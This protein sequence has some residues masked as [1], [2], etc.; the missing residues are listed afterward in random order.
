MMRCGRENMCGPCWD[1]TPDE[2]WAICEAT[3]DLLGEISGHTAQRDRIRAVVG[4]VCERTDC[5][6]P[7]DIIT[8][9]VEDSL[10]GLEI[11]TW[12]LTRMLTPEEIE[13]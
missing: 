8:Q 5:V 2:A 6:R 13:E 1:A 11:E 3:Y 12:P 7:S 9:G 4:E 10:L